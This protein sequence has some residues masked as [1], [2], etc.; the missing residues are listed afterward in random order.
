ML[1]SMFCPVHRR[2][3]LSGGLWKVTLLLFLTTDFA[4]G[5]GEAL[6]N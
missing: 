5:D 3:L 6:D 1:S 4:A 2:A